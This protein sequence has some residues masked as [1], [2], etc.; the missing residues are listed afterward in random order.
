MQDKTHTQMEFTQLSDLKKIVDQQAVKKRIVLCSA[1][2]EHALEAIKNAYEKGIITPVLVA[3]KEDLLACAKNLNFDLTDIECHFER[4]LPAIIKKSISMVTAQKAD[5]L[6]KGK[7]STAELLSG[8][9]NKEWGL[10]TRKFLSH[11]AIF[12]IPE[13]HK[14]L[15]ITDVAFNIAPGLKEKVAIVKNAVDFS[16]R[17]GVVNPKI[18][19]VAAVEMV[20]EKMSATTD[21]ALLSIMQRRGQIKDCL[22]DG[23][24]SFDNAISF[25]SK[26]SKGLEG[27]VAGD[28]DIILVPNIEAGNMLY[29]SF[30][31]FANAKLCGIV[32][33]APFPIVL[34]SRA[35]SKDTKYNSILLASAASN[36]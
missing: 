31:F 3:K 20:N 36:E 14:L 25:E 26:K 5:I 32:L 33:G 35:D 19:A 16:K 8:V 11:Y 29:K 18:A 22:I 9:L 23:P 2:D 12:E 30:V 1:A 6:M 15:G 7:L 27:P 24:L 4:D 10:K 13:Y 21:A 34:T 28:A 17:I